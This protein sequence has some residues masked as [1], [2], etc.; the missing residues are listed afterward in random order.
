MRT[1]TIA[2]ATWRE[3]IRQ[4][5]AIIVLCVAALVT[6][7]SQFINFFHFDVEAASS[8]IRQMAVAQT[9]MG[10]M[11]IA[12]FTASAV[13]ADEIESRT[14]L[15][16]LAKPVRRYQIILGKFAGIMLAVFVAF[17][18]MVSVS[19]VTAWWAEADQRGSEARVEK[20]RANP[21]LAITELP[22]L[23]TGQGTL[24][25]ADSYKE[26]IT[27]REGQGLDYLQ[28]LGDFLVLSSG[29]TT[30]LI[31]RAPLA[32]ELEDRRGF[33][34]RFVS[35]LPAASPGMASLVANGL[36]F[37][38]NR[39]GLLFK[40]FLLAFV[41][42]MVIAA[43]A[44]AVSTRLPL[45]FNALICS[46]AFVVGNV[47]FDLAE[48]LRAAD[49]GAGGLGLAARVAA[50]PVIAF[51]YALPNFENL[52]LTEPLATGIGRIGPAVWGYGALYGLVYTSMALAVAVLLFRRREVA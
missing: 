15:T 17:A 6:Y 22:A 38:S 39:T 30:Q 9:L 42:V 25:V 43:I 40:A 16:L 32:T 1:L 24:G 29:Q 48:M 45:V 49:F 51:C 50:W 31:A 11:V 10:G 33:S 2:M 26:L 21:A 20:W 12:V 44:T 36:A 34:G 18:V 37:L 14:I 47:S 52:S 46:A 19:V 7:L 27:R 5:V 35:R 4:P 8:G 23:T 13:L 41:H 3:A 28:S